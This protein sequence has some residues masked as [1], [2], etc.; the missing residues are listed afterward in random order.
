MAKVV[1][2]EEGAEVSFSRGR[3]ITQ[4]SNHDVAAEQQPNKDDPAEGQPAI[5]TI[6]RASAGEEGQR[7][8]GAVSD[9]A[10]TGSGV[11][12]SPPRSTTA[13]DRS[14]K[15]QE[16]EEMLHEARGLES[17]TLASVEDKSD[18]T[19]GSTSDASPS[20]DVDK[21]SGMT[22]FS[23]MRQDDE[24]SLGRPDAGLSTH[25]EQVEDEESTT[26]TSMKVAEQNE[27]EESELSNPR[28]VRQNTGVARKFVR[29]NTGIGPDDGV[30]TDGK[31][32]KAPFRVPQTLYMGHPV[33]SPAAEFLERQQH[34]L[35]EIKTR[36][37]QVAG[38]LELVVEH[39]PKST[40][41]ALPDIDAV[42]PER[43]GRENSQ[44]DWYV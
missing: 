33:G 11:V 35:T 37:Q 3:D 31:K 28:F 18:A 26:E 13:V 38:L 7:L 2:T 40:G 43:R 39:N 15:P 14:R 21:H 9:T 27:E 23:L 4:P 41:S 34:R 10:E 1:P 20:L 29:Q 30:K 42:F 6:A 17:G 16:S 8:S 24:S 44:G 5:S 19:G 22:T 12:L 25:T 32:N 36:R